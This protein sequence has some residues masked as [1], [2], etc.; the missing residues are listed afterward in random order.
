MTVRSL[1]YRTDLFFPRFDGDVTDHG[2]HI[3][4]RT[5]A[6]PTFYWGNFLLFT[7]PPVEGDLERWQ[8]LFAEEIGS[9][10]SVRH[11][12]F[13]WDGTAGEAGDVGP[14]LDAGFTVDESVVLTARTVTRPAKY[15]GEVVVRALS[16]DWE[17]EA[18]LRNQVACR[19]PEHDEAGYLVYR[20]RK[21]ESY[22]AMVRAGLGEWFGAFLGERLVGDLGVFVVDGIGRF[23]SVGTHPDFRRRGVCG[24][25]VHQ[26]A[27]HALG[28]LGA[29]VLVMRADAHSHAAR[30]YESIGFAPAERQM[31]M[32]WWPR[33]ME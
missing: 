32:T 22:R 15:A 24:A 10:P 8:G 7:A 23:Q 27:R 19:D 4:V 9:T 1:G 29:D 3:A 25:L 2:D 16:A 13:G 21:T 31:G 17:W 30:I 26:V 5:P 14:F 18:A 11:F 6:N 33:T 20:A 28:T 12:A